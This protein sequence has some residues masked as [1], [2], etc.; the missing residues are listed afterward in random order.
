MANIFSA[1]VSITFDVPNRCYGNC[2]DKYIPKRNG[3]IEPEN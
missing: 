2:L 1:G 3:N